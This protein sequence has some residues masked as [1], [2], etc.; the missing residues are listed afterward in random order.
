M[1]DIQEN[2]EKKIWNA[3]LDYDKLDRE[4]DKVKT[5]VFLGKSAAFLGSLMCSLNFAWTSD[6]KTACTNGTSLYWNPYWFQQLPFETRLT[7]LVHELWHVA[8]LHMLR[9]GDRDPKVWNYACDIAINNMLKAEGYSFVGTDPWLEPKYGEQPA[10][11]IYDDMRG[12]PLITMEGLTIWGHEEGG[13]GDEEDILDPG[14]NPDGTIDEKAAA[15]GEFPIINQVVHAS[16]TAKMAG[17]P[18]SV[19]GEVESVLKR[20]LSPKLPW[21][22]LLMNFF[23]EISDFDYSWARPNRR[24]QDVYLPSLVESD[25]GLEHLIYYLDVSGSVSDGEV[26]RF[27]SE[28]K[29]IKDQFKPQKLTLVLF[30]T[31]IQRE[32]V[33]LEEDPFEEVVIVGRGG[34]CLRCVREHMIQHKPTAAVVFS[35]MCCAPMEPL[36]AGVSINTI[37]VGVNAYKGAQVPFGKLIHI[38]E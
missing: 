23:N 29:Y 19:P 13:I 35:D 18:G 20:F 21:E 16:H 12:Q 38:K 15:I 3:D 33:F 5:K 7:V 4:L 32:Y 26:L 37:W 8:L 22:T 2:T 31:I 14:E 17:E 34:T 11:E 25:N 24:Y 27:N 28:V 30:D 1:T 6:I 9:R 36:P 10:E